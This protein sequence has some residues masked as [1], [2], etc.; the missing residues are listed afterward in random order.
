[1]NDRPQS[2]PIACIGIPD[3]N[4]APRPRH[5]AGAALL[6]DRAT[7]RELERGG[8]RWE[9][10]SNELPDDGKATARVSCD[11]QERTLQRGTTTYTYAVCSECMALEAKFRAAI[12]PK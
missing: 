2:N 7:Y 1:M 11:G 10:R 12:A 3:G 8:V 9:T 6:V 5:C 4:P